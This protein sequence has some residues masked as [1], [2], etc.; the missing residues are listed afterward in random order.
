[1]PPALDANPAWYCDDLVL[2]EFALS[3]GLTPKSCASV[4]K[5][6]NSVDSL[7][8]D[9]RLLEFLKTGVAAELDKLLLDIDRKML[10]PLLVA[11]AKGHGHL[12]L[13]A[14]YEFDFEL[15]PTAGMKFWRPHKDL[16]H[17]SGNSPDP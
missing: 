8:I 2:N 13:R 5:I 3:L 17:W 7:V 11:A 1:M 6:D 14:G 4:D 12:V 16:S 10:K 9:L 15:K